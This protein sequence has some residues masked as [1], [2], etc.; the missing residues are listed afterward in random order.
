MTQ[1]E[2]AAFLSITALLTLTPGADTA[3]VTKNTLAR[4]RRA[5]FL[6]TL[7]IA[8]GCLAHATLS[9]LGLSAI[10]A[11]S[12]AVYGAVKLA[13][14]LYLIWVGWKSLRAAVRTPSSTLPS[15]SSSSSKGASGEG[16]SF[17]EGLLTNLLN[18]KVG[19]F[20]LSFLPQFIRSGESLLWWSLALAMI[21][22]V[23]GILWLNF[24]AAVIARARRAWGGNGSGSALTRWLEGATGVLLVGLGVR[25]AVDR[26]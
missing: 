15:A 5:A 13:G 22:N 7:G 25:L 3:L 21:H 11:Q 8:T 24:Y 26:R 1:A 19:I 18:P 4:G 17:R 16:Q 23:M 9:A 6:T 10:L 12:A 14:A 2:W 20:Y